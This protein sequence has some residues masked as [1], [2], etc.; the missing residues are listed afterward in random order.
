M[1]I[2]SAADF[3]GIT[4]AGRVVAE[5]LAAMVQATQAGVTTGDLDAIGAAVLK[6]HG[7]RSA[8]QAM[9]GCPTVTLISVNDEVVHGLPGSRMLKRGDVVKL[10]VTADTGGYIADAATTVLLPGASERSHQLRDAAV[11]AFDAGCRVARAGRRVSAIGLAVEREVSSR[12][13]HVL[14]EL[15]GHGVGRAIHESPTV[16]NYFDPFQ[17]DVLTEGLVLTI[18][19]LVSE[20]RTRV[21][22]GEDGW[23]LRTRNGCLAAHHEHTIIITSGQPTIVTML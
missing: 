1:S 18:E 10:D 16:P 12:G 4:R 17:A 20:R 19:P 22:E 2:E 6:T 13:F 7:A 23:T 11:S 9:Y 5:A 14:R 15:S 3:D 8:P 21:V